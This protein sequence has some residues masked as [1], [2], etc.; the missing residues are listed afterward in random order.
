MKN[1]HPALALLPLLFFVLLFFGAGL[2]FSLRGDDMGFYHL[3]AQVALIPAIGLALFLGRHAARRQLDV[4]L[5][6][7]GHSSIMLMALIFIFAGAF[8]TVTQRVGGVDAAVY[9]GMQAI[10]AQFLLPG[11][12][13]V[14]GL[15]SLA[16]GTSMGT[17]AA[18]APIALGVAEAAGLNT[19]LVI[20][21]VI[22]GAMFGD[23][24]SVISDTTI[25]AT[26]TQGASMRDKFRENVWIA[27]P[28]AL[29]TLLVLALLPAPHQGAA[30][31]PAAAILALPYL[32]VLVLAVSGVNVLAVLAIGVVLAGLIG[33]FAVPDYTLVTFSGDV[34]AG[35]ESMLGI[36]LLTIFVGGLAALIRD[37]GGLA[38]LTGRIMRLGGKKAG[39]RTGEAG[40][41]LLGA[42]TDV[43]VANNTVAILITG[44]M[45]K[46]LATRRDI[47]PA[48]SASLLDIFSCVV[49]GI[50]PYGAQILLAASIAGLSPFALAGNVYYCWL[51]ALVTLVALATGWPR[52]AHAADSTTP[53]TGGPE[54][55]AQQNQ[56]TQS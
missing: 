49:Q 10:P 2:Y 5:E 16:I 48:R 46:D 37:Q 53:E 31:E 27:L 15:M 33:L 41:G 20:G 52:R 38:W 54:A 17:I 23:N 8:A 7:M 25:A 47:T 30:V 34:W 36:T 28:A 45:A 18:V 56:H 43:F 26:Q 21:T 6:G 4:L 55:L 35:F 44:P 14:A 9:L 42:L 32:V 12:F 40:I 3:Q 24:L 22:G 51:L 50:L 29:L 39:R 11:L 1:Q 13:A 19:A